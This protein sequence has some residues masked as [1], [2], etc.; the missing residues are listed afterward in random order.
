MNV[1]TRGVRN[2]FR[3]GIRTT[4]IVIILSLSVALALAMVMARG[5]VQKKIDSVKSSVGTTVSIQPAGVQGFEG[6]GEPL[7][8]QA[9]TALTNIAHVESVTQT[10]QDRLTTGE[11]TTLESAVEAGSLGMRFRDSSGGSSTNI[12]PPTLPN[13]KAFTPPIMVSATTDLASS[14]AANNGKL[15]L[16]SGAAFDPATTENVALVGKELATK[17]NL[18][19]GST[20][21]AYGTSIKVVGIYDVGSKFANNSV[22]LPLASLQKLSSQ[23]GEISSA[24]AKVDSIGNV[25]AAVTAI[26]NKLGSTA[27]VTSRQSEA[28]TALEPLENIK[29]VSL[30]SLIGAVIAGAVIILLTMIMI[31]R[32]R[33]REI[34]VLKAIGASNLKVMLQFMSEA[35]TFTIIAAVIGI[36]LGVVGGNPVTKMLV[37][38]NSPTTSQPTLPGG[39]GQGSKPTM[40]FRS[41]GG[42]RGVA[43]NLGLGQ[44]NLKNVQ[45]VVG[46]NVLLYGL[47][48]ALLIALAGSAT[49]ALLI[50]KIRPAEVMRT[51]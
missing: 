14:A 29:T 2:A 23:E 33:R 40:V 7:K 46:W 16:S 43:H 35:V 37:N 26:K 39:P 36:A 49:A 12:D 20:F 10:L 13:G 6:G 48:A 50:A 32:E 45:A 24:S 44:E 17:N 25:S 19:V 8:S 51:E 47:G 21:T 42:P 1:F 41:E 30:F 15:S 18:S 5:A 3:N 9:V 22:V 34:G 11:N 31:V 38:N 27:D 4:S 28:E